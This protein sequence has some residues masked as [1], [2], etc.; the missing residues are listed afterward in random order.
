MQQVEI[1]Q[2]RYSIETM[3]GMSSN[4]SG[5]ILNH[6]RDD[7]NHPLPIAP[8][9][10]HA[11]QSVDYRQPNFEQPHSQPSAGHSNTIFGC[12]SG[13]F[14][15]AFVMLNLTAFISSV[16][17]VIVAAVLPSVTAD[18]HG[19]SNQAFW[20]GTGFLLASTIAQPIYGTFSEIFGRRIN[21]QVS[22]FWFLLGSI[23]CTV[24][25]NMVFFVIS[26][27]VFPSKVAI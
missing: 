21:L 4:V 3:A 17:S 26:R 19:S 5:Q 13:R 11:H 10:L 6:N 16:D 24:S 27:I 18:L 15:L 20:S 14:W 1:T 7:D 22:L 2:K 8:S 23:L 25:T 12:K 9:S